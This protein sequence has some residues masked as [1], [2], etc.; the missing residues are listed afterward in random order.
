MTQKQIEREWIAY[1]STQT[2]RK[3]EMFK[4]W[5]RKDAEYAERI[6]NTQTAFHNSRERLKDECSAL[7]DLLHNFKREGLR[8]IAKQYEEAHAKLEDVHRK[9]AALKKER[10]ECLGSISAER[11]EC[12]NKFEQQMREINAEIKA[13]FLEMSKQIQNPNEKSDIDC[14]VC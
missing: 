9:L 5:S 6:L 7:T 13:T 1:K 11:L 10:E 4:E 3:G 2:A 14:I 12:R 8:N